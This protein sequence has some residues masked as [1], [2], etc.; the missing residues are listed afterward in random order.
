MASEGNA[1]MPFPAQPVGDIQEGLTACAEA[2]L[3]ENL[4]RH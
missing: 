3:V 4:W 2:A 1:T